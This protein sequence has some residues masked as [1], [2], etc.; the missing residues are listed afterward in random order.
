VNNSRE[1]LFWWPRGLGVERHIPCGEILQGRCLIDFSSV[2]D[3][4]HDHLDIVLREDPKHRIWSNLYQP[5]GPGSVRFGG[6][7][8]AW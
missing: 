5:V 4:H 7:R 8:K 3:P 6:V 1:R 2:C